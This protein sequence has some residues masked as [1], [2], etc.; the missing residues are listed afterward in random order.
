[1]R[2]LVFEKLGSIV[3]GGVEAL[4][5]HHTREWRFGIEI[6]LNDPVFL[7]ELDAVA[8]ARV[9]DLVAGY[10]RTVHLPFYGLNL[11]CFDRWIADYSERTI[12]DGIDFCRRIDADRAVTHTTVPFYLGEDARDKWIGRFLERMSLLEAHAA[13]NG[14]TLVWENTYERDFSL[15]DAMIDRYPSVSFCLDVGH[16]YCF[17]KRPIADFVRHL[18]E[19]IRHLHLHDNDALDDRHWALGKGTVD[20]GAVVDLL[21]HTAADTAVFELE[22][23]DFRESLPQIERFF[24]KII[25]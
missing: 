23:D 1:M 3:S 17:A 21:P 12:R 24:G 25:S 15:F 11:G 5:H 7:R 19:R 13:Q 6:T 8:V 2:F 14:V 16:A 9:K 4:V 20:F 10:D 18:G 22:A